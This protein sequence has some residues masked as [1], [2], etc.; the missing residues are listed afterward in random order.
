MRSWVN[1]IC[2]T[3]LS[4]PHCIYGG[5]SP[6]ILCFFLALKGMILFPRGFP[7]GGAQKIF[8]EIPKHQVRIKMYPREN[9]LPGVWVQELTLF[10]GPL[11]WLTK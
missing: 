4:N 11:E 7:L 1:H 9:V 10:K 3:P 2:N 5:K 8:G 6:I